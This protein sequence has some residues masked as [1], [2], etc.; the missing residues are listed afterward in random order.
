M[1]NKNFLDTFQTILSL[2]S[3][4]YTHSNIIMEVDSRIVLP[5]D[6]IDVDEE[7]T[8][9]LGPGLRQEGDQIV[10][11]KAGILQHLPVGNR[12]W[13]ES[14]QKRVCSACCRGR[15]EDT[16]RTVVYRSNRRISRWNSDCQD[17]RVFP[18]G[19]WNSTFSRLAY[20][21]I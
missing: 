7:S 6:V 9:V 19:Y 2:H 10:A 8:I 17:G 14:N 21:G 16:K 3:Y 15:Q 18:C 13:I 5:G 12:Y 1:G 11:M 20:A 4:I